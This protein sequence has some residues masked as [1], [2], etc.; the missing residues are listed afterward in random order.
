MSTTLREALASIYDLKEA[1]K[2]RKKNIANELLGKYK[3]IIPPDK[4]STEIIRKLR[5]SLHGKTKNS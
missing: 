3:G 5:S 1:T 2:D 4:A